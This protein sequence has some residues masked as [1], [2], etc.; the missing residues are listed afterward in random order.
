MSFSLGPVSKDLRAWLLL[1]T[2]VTTL[3]GGLSS[4]GLVV[5]ESGFDPLLFIELSKA[6]ICV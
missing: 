4:S 3:V 6:A 2:L 1:L 5:V